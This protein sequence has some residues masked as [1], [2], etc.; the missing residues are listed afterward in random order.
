MA[1]SIAERLPARTRLT[2]SRIR[3]T[4]RRR[5]RRWTVSRS[6]SMDHGSPRPRTE[7]PIVTSSGRLRLPAMSAH[8][9]SGSVHLTSLTTTTSRQAAL[10]WATMCRRRSRERSFSPVTCHGSAGVHTRGC[11]RPSI[12]AAVS[13]ENAS[14]TP[15]MQPAAERASQNDAVGGVRTPQIGALRSLRRVR[16]RDTFRA[17]ASSTRNA[18]WARGSGNAAGVRMIPGWSSAHRIEE[19]RPQSSSPIPPRGHLR[20]L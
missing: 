17:W 11:H 2:A 13:W 18:R 6:A 14:S 10:R 3:S 9:V 15:M 1:D 4:S 19:R 12:R 20:P 5:A 16:P 8:V 7:S